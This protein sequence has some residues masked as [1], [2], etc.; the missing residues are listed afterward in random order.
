MGVFKLSDIASSKKA[1]NKAF[2]LSEMKRS[3]INIPE[4][5]VLDSDIYSEIIKEIGQNKKIEELL[6]SLNSDNI[7]E[8]SEKL[9]LISDKL[10]ISDSVFSELKKFIDND[11]KYAV[12]SSGIKEDLEGFSFAGQYESFINVTGYDNIKDAIKK[13]YSSMFSKTVLS[14]LL[15][16]KINAENLK[17]AVIIQEMV[18]S[19]ISGVAFTVNPISGNDKEI[20]IEAAAG[21]GENLVS[22]KVKAQKYAYNWFDEKITDSCG[23]ILSD[24]QVKIIAEK[25]LEIQMLF[26]YPCDIEFAFSCGQL[27]ILQARAITKIMYGG[28]KDQW[29]TADFKDGGVSATVCTPYMWSLYEYVWEN[30]FK[31]FLLDAKILK[32]SQLRKLGDMFYGRPYWNLSVAKTAMSMVPGYKERDF[33]SEIGVKITYEGEGQTTKITPKTIAG[34]IKM[35]LEQKRIV[36][37]RKNN[38]KSLKADLLAKYYKYQKN[39]DETYSD[40]EF[41]KI[42]EALVFDD[43]LLSEST[44]FRQIFINTIHQSLFKDKILKHTTSGGYFNLI[45]GLDNISHLLPFYDMW[46]IS[47]KIREEKKSF[48]YWK[49]SNVSDINTALENGESSFFINEVENHIKSFGYHSEKEL[50]VTYPC[51]YEDTKTVIKAFKETVILDEE[52]SPV[53][54]RQRLINSFNKE[55]ENI[56]EKTSSSKYKKLLKTVTDMRQMLWWREEFRDVSTR[57]YY[58]IRI[59]TVRLAK[60][61]VEQRVISCEDDIWF[62]KIKD[63]KSY[64]NNEITSDELKKIIARNRKYYR[65]F[66]NFMS[67]NEIG[68]IFDGR[69]EQKSEELLCGI[70]C[71]N[72]TVTA[73]ARVIESLAETDRLEVGDILVTKFTDTGW[74]SKFAIL[75]G[76][77]TEYGG[78]LCHAAIVSREYGIP[79]IVCAQDA[80]KLI[81]DG[82]KISINGETGKI[83]VIE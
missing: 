8:V 63:I 58:I 13:C 6:S 25:A 68:R 81:K 11:K 41:K 57:F 82:A 48:L 1:G 46:N 32:P 33:D 16:N 24:E 75:S 2:A 50:D 17:M 12:R 71:N 18:D 38:A 10:I 40:D 53:E 54:D 35:A 3:G 55:L 83:T 64:I 29:T 15:N 28:I 60:L 14:Y 45:G 22:G 34:I 59:Y 78:I 23:E 52:C 37:N 62:A 65:S 43:Y 27:Y 70:G 26:G 72:G 56:K 74:T 61:L 67:E 4:G 20:V 21:Q 80:T 49:N 5:F 42:W 31:N 9:S 77:I 39:A 36:S 19:E 30:E 69:R 73:T 76:I 51:Y 79:C 47:R 44:Y 7:E 66:E